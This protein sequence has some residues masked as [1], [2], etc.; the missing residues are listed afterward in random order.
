MGR[1]S[2]PESQRRGSAPPH[3]PGRHLP[4]GRFRTAMGVLT[5]LRHGLGACGVARGGARGAR[6]DAIH[7][8]GTRQMR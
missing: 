3:P 1:N 6:V 5:S 7:P 4:P 8:A 2:G